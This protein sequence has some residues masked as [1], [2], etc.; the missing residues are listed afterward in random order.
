LS[1]KTI[2][3]DATLIPGMKITVQGPISPDG[4]TLAFEL[5]VDALLSRPMLDERLDVLT[6]ALRRQRAIEELPLTK[7]SLVTNL[8]LY[9]AQRKA[10]ATHE[11]AMNA[12]IAARSANRRVEAEAAAGDVNALSQFDARLA[13]IDGQIKLARA[14]IPYLEAIIAGDEPPEL[15]PEAANDVKMAAE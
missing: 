10:R 7:A 3:V 5:P 9:A 8:G 6:G 12:R 1:D 13:Q 11:A 4:Q 15:F 2:S 14:R